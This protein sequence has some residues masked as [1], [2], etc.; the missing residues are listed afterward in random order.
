MA[1]LKE[2]ITELKEI[3]A[4]VEKVQHQVNG[5]HEGARLIVIAFEIEK[6]IIPSL[7]RTV[8]RMN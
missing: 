8:S 1:N 2:L 6:V 5:T 4:R 7:K 3:Q